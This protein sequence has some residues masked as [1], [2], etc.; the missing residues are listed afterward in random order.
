MYKEWGH[1]YHLGQRPNLGPERLGTEPARAML[2]PSRPDGGRIPSRLGLGR[3]TRLSLMHIFEVADRMQQNTDGL[4]CDV[5]STFAGQHPR[6]TSDQRRNRFDQRSICI[7]SFDTA[8][9]AR[10]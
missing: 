5:A 8:A 1:S 6:T 4:V 2:L 10:L 7:R 3:L 9:I